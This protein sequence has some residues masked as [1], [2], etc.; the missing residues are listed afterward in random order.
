M[1]SHSAADRHASAHLSPD[2][3]L[4][5]LHLF[6]AQPLHAH[7]VGVAGIGRGLRQGRR[8]TGGKRRRWGRGHFLGEG[9]LVGLAD[10]QGGVGLLPGLGRGAAALPAQEGGELGLLGVGEDGVGRV[11]LRGL[12]SARRLRGGVGGRKHGGLTPV[13]RVVELM[14]GDLGSGLVGGG[15][16]SRVGLGLLQLL[17]WL[18]LGVMVALVVVVMVVAA[19][20]LQILPRGEH[21]VEWWPAGQEGA[22]R[23][24][25]RNRDDRMVLESQ[26][27]LRQSLQGR[28]D[29]GRGVGELHGGRRRRGTLGR[30]WDVVGARGVGEG[31]GVV[32]AAV[33]VAAGAAQL[34]AQRVRLLLVLETHLHKHKHKHTKK[35]KPH[36]PLKTDSVYMSL[37]FIVVMTYYL[38]RTS[39]TELLISSILISMGKL[40]WHFIAVNC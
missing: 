40:H 33:H 26:R 19:P 36:L 31:V 22:W 15:V 4:G 27:R 23:R 30:R 25:G 7:V 35:S 18:L 1:T 21:L 9:A 5:V 14:A 12:G 11:G 10:G 28:Y 34:P 32:A 39:K 24:R 3:A 17:L 20:V 13:V 38:S 16:Y 2:G 29:R 37:S 8:L 6:P